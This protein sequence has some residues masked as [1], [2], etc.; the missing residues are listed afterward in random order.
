MT[1]EE[2][3][4]QDYMLESEKSSDNSVKA[5]MLPKEKYGRAHKTYSHLSVILGLLLKPSLDPSL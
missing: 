3:K 2:E 5:H 4:A 1:R